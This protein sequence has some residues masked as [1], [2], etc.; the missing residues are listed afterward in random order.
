M[1][2]VTVLQVA[3]RLTGT[4]RRLSET[5]R[6]NAAESGCCVVDEPILAH[7]FVHAHV[8]LAG[9]IEAALDCVAPTAPPV[10]LLGAHVSQRPCAA[11]QTG[12]ASSGNT[13]QGCSRPAESGVSF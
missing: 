10:V 4:I 6:A 13:M 11:G 5:R 1:H 7:P 8:V 12:Q 3:R 2:A 9:V